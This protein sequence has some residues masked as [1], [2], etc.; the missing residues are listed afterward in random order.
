MKLPVHKL[1]ELDYYTYNPFHREGKFPYNYYGQFVLYWRSTRR[2]VSWFWGLIQYEKTHTPPPTI[3]NIATVSGKGD[4]SK[5]STG[6]LQL[7]KQLQ[8]WVETPTDPDLEAMLDELNQ[9]Q[10]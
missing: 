1:R 7:D 6:A 8:K 2:T 5:E 9:R 10:S 4:S 3:L